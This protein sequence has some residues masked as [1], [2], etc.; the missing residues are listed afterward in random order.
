MGGLVERSPS[1]LGKRVARKPSPVITSG[2]VQTPVAG[3][4]VRRIASVHFNG[5]YGRRR[6]NIPVHVCI[7]PYD[8]LGVP[9]NDL[10]R[11]DAITV[12]RIKGAWY[13]PV[14]QNTADGY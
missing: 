5:I 4:N 1:K 6:L 2:I 3:E 7:R 8:L 12:H 13:S 10:V 11:I 9:Q 14:S